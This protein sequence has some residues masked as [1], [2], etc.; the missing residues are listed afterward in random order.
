MIRAVDQSRTLDELDP[1]AWG[2][3][4]YDSYLVT[5]CHRLRRKPLREFSTEDLRIMIG[6][7]IGT[8][9]LV[10]L[11][12]AALEQEPLAGG[13]FYPGALLKAVL[14]VGPEFWSLHPE[15]RERAEAVLHGIAELPSELGDAV[16]SFRGV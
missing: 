14:G 2:S 5:T 8:R 12:L 4:E 7:G 6:Q 11:A 10:P 3:P 9:W 13:H 1:P 16:S 15:L